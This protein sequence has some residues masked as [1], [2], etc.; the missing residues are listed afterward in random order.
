MPA[1]AGKERNR[2]VDDEPLDSIRHALRQ[3]EAETT[4][5]IVDDEREPLEAGRVE[6]SL[7][8]GLITLDRI[9]EVI[10]L[11]GA[12]EAGEIG[13]DPADSLQERVPLPGRG[14]DPVEVE[15]RRP[16]FVRCLPPLGWEPGDLP[17]SL[18]HV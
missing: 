16:A 6:E 5:P 4:A 2:G 1:V 18:E 3:G 11:R 15:D 17:G 14:R 9:V 10:G 8:P 13:G 12:A 7:Q